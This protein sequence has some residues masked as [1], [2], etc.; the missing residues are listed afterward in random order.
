VVQRQRRSDHRDECECVEW[1]TY[2]RL[3]IEVDVDRRQ[4]R[5]DSHRPGW[6]TVGLN[7][8]G[9]WKLTW[10]AWKYSLCRV[11]PRT[12]N[13]AQLSQF[14]CDH[15]VCSAVSRRCHYL[16]CV[17][18][19]CHKV[20][21]MHTQDEPGARRHRTHESQ[22]N[23]PWSLF[24]SYQSRR[25]KFFGRASPSEVRGYLPAHTVPKCHTIKTV[26]MLLLLLLLL[27]V[28]PV[29]PRARSPDAAHIY[30]R[31]EKWRVGWC[32]NA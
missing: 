7:H 22:V 25:Q 30:R 29:P 10:P 17:C 8:V 31:T 5:A 16:S 12:V 21:K 23:G 3:T 9:F 4:W 20:S 19:Y 15:C 11:D 2:W 26:L 14:A 28:C 24:C 27:H 13:P 18:S 32:E 1:H 6:P